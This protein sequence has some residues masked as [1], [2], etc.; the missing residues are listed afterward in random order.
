M[1]VAELP[2]RQIAIGVVLVLFA[3]WLFFLLQVGSGGRPDPIPA[4]LKPYL[5]DDELEGSKV[6]KVGVLGLFTALALAIVMAGYW[7]FIPKLQ[8][9]ASQR[10]LKESVERGKERFDVSGSNL[11]AL[12]CAGCHGGGQGGKVDYI[13]TSG[14]DKGK[15]VSWECPSLVDVYFRFSRDEVKQIL[16]YGRPGTP[17]PAWGLSGGGPLTD[18]EIEDLLNYLKSIETTPEDAVKR[19]GMDSSGNKITDGKALFLKDCAR[20]H[21]PK[22]SYTAADQRPDLAQGVG[23]Y[24][25]NLTNEPNQFPDIK[26]QIDFIKS[27]SVANKPYGVRGIGN[28]RMPGMQKDPD[29]PILDDAQIRAVAEYE[30]SLA[31][32][33]GLPAPYAQA[34][35]SGTVA[36][37]TGNASGGAASGGAGP[38]GAG[39]QE[40]GTPA[41]PGATTTVG[42]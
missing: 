16:I 15:K 35:A 25:P 27:G 30:R 6:V 19:A 23:A 20:C 41:T 31:A 18:Q 37:P 21:T 7:L 29:H 8:A 26:D 9:D 22:F 28:G 39:G 32:Q 11:K 33:Y 3:V 1:L 13:L 34:D 24:G 36:G 2:V 17:M 5:T 14:P 4:N 10:Y 12:N 42:R 38:T 40:T